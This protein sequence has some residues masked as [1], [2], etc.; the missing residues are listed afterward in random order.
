MQYLTRHILETVLTRNQW[1]PQP[2]SRVGSITNLILLTCESLEHP[3]G[4]FYKDK[5]NNER[6]Y[7]NQKGAYMLDMMTDQI[8]LNI[9]MPK[10]ERYLLPEILKAYNYLGIKSPLNL[11]LSRP[12]Y[13]MRG[14]L[15]L[16]TCRNRACHLRHHCPN[17]R[18][19]S[20]WWK[21]QM[22]WI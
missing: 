8:L 5:R 2:H 18:S 9:I 19:E 13:R 3:S 7:Q 22:M 11:W 12:I 16:I 20:D 17:L 4:F 10:Q 21:I 6:C 1:E 15:E 14:S